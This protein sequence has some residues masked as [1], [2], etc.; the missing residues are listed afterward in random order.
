[1][2]WPSG[3]ARLT[4]RAGS[5]VDG[6]VLHVM[7]RMMAR[8]AGETPADAVNLLTTLAADYGRAEHFASPDTYFLP[9]PMPRVHARHVEELAGG[10]AIVDLSWASAH[11]PFLADFREEFA[12][13]H[14]NLTVHARWWRSPRPR[15]TIVLLHGWGGGAW[16]LESRAFPVEYFRRLGLDVVLFQLPFHAL[17]APRG[18]RSGELFPSP[19]VVRTNE[20][21]TQAISDLR[22][23]RTWLLEE[24][25]VPRL[26]V[27]GMSLGGYTTALFASLVP[28]L[29]FAVPMIP[30]ACFADL[31]W[32]NGEATPAR[33]RAMAAG[34]TL[35]LLEGA[36]RVHSPLARTP[37]V[38]PERRF[39]I[40]G[41]GDRI[42][43]PDQ[44][45]RLWRH[46]GEPP[47]HW[48]PGG[49]L[50]Q[51]GRGDAFRALG[52]WLRPLI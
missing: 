45:E 52:K 41:H 25:D 28:D 44:A 34:V 14:E 1:M 10:G 36:F 40:A 23:L 48:F 21:F 13:H 50:A 6:A 20:A 22:A 4:S 51:V 37:L 12:A 26:G 38:A 35:P 46:W 2:K 27:A 39:I 9:P 17:R 16:F 47:I 24:H 32:R 30:A 8:A 33:K 29:A 5:V 15:T 3:L 43:P 18:T 42:T 31:M 19:H 7:E 11:V 49:H